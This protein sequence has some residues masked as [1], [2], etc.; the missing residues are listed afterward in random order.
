ML[1]EKFCEASLTTTVLAV[2]AVAVLYPSSKSA[3]KLVTSVFDVTV[4]GAVPV[5]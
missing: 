4:S 5:A 1:A 2:D 3:F